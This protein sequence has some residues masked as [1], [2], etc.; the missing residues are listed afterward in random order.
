MSESVGI[1]AF[2]SYLPERELTSRHFF[3]DGVEP[4]GNSPL[5]KAPETRR[6]V[7]RG[8][9]A[10]ELIER[11]ARP[12]FERLA[13]DP[14]TGIDAVI[15]NVLLPDLPITGCG[16]EVAHRLGC[17][18]E[19]I[20]D[21]HNG[22]CASFPYMLKIARALVRSG[23]ARSVLLCNVQ[24]TAGQVFSQ[25]GLSREPQAAVPGDGC[26]VA[27]VTAGGGSPVLA[28][29]TRN[30]PASAVDMAMSLP[31]G[32][33]YWEPGTAEMGIEFNE[34][35][36][37]EI[38]ERGNR[39]VPEV[40]RE[41]CDKIGVETSAIDVLITNQPNRMYMRNWHQALGLAPER[42]LHTFD[43]FGNLYGASVPVTL[44][45]AVRAGGVRE[46]NLVLVAG[47][48]HAGDFAAAAAFRWHASEV[49]DE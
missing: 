49:V 10:S 37:R 5:F 29:T 17:S 39:M 46:G 48:A 30:D 16:A 47:F 19:W 14:A 23:D 36:R 35:S 1:V 13:V 34:A 3:P 45:H 42:H 22:G 2:G 41:T 15:T 8:E 21:L 32:R 43:R 33:R 11:A 28:V 6:H 18:P 38:I 31:D 12:M 25:P 26:G 27:Y 20:L 4:M 7:R 44:D 24:N 40:V 9:R